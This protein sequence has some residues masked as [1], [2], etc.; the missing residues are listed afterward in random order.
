MKH[1]AISSTEDDV[2]LA[3]GWVMDLDAC[4]SCGYGLLLLDGR[5]LLFGLLLVG[6]ACDL[7]LRFL[8]VIL[9]LI[10]GFGRL[11]PGETEAA[12]TARALVHLHRCDSFVL[13]GEF[14][15]YYLKLTPS[16]S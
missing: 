8:V 12:L 2:G 14:H 16:T 1:K 11:V 4:L 10:G 3:S 5:N 7:L 15:I 6:L 9:R 13:L